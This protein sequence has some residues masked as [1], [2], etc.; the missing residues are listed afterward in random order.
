[1]CYFYTPI[2]LAATDESYEVISSIDKALEKLEFILTASG[3]VKW[4]DQF[5]K[6]FGSLLR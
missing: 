1:M 5:A 6:L 4:H 3:N 2:R